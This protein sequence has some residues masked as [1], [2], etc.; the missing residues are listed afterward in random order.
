MSLGLVAQ[1][2]GERGL[3]VCTVQGH[4]PLKQVAAIQK[5]KISNIPWQ[6]PLTDGLAV[7]M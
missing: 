2:L 1:D 4:N 7:K 6:R 5:E 3:L